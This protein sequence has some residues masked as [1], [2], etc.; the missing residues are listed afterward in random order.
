MKFKLQYYILF[1]FYLVLFSCN[2]HKD[3]EIKSE[4]INEYDYKLSWLKTMKFELDSMT[5]PYSESFQIIGIEDD[6]YMT[7][8]NYE[9]QTIYYYDYKK[10][11]F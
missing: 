3:K 10:R 4:D 8:L 5:L 7:F 6:L 2:N 9:T 11:H 1:L